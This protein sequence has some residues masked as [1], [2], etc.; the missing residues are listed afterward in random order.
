MPLEPRLDA[1]LS[2]VARRL[3]VAAMLRAAAWSLV[4]AGVVAAVLA[5]QPLGVRVAVA[6]AA[7]VIVCVA[8]AVRARQLA[9]R[10]HAATVAEQHHPAFQNLLVTAEE[11][12]AHPERAAAWVRERVTADATARSAGF[13]AAAAVPL[14][15]AALTAIGAAV[16]A[17]LG[18]G[19]RPQHAAEIAATLAPSLTQGRGAGA[20]TVTVEIEPAAYTGLPRRVEQDPE[21]IEIVGGTRLRVRLAGG[22]GTHRM[23]LGTRA[24]DVRT[25]DGE[26]VA[27]AI[28]EE[29][30]YLAVESDRLDAARLIPLRV[31]PDRAPVV[32]IDAPARDL[33]LPP[34]AA[35]IPVSA[36]AQDDFGLEQLEIRYTKVSGSGEQFEFED[37]T[38]PVQLERN[39]RAWTAAGTLPLDRL[40]L[41]PGD[42][43]VYRAV[44]R[45]ARPGAAGV[46]ESDTFF[47]EIQG[48]SQVLL[49]GLEMPPERERYALSQQMVVMKIERLRAREKE[50]APADVR[51]EAAL[52][53][54]EQ[55]MVRANFIFL[56]GGHVEDEVVE[57]EQ[58]HEIQEGRLEN[59][60]RQEISRAVNLMTAAEMGLTAVNTGE[61][62]PPARAAVQ[63]LQV[64]FGRNRYLLRS[65]AVQSRIDPSRRLTGGLDEAGDWRRARAEPDPA[66]AAAAVRELLSGIVSVISAVAAGDDNQGVRLAQLA[67]HALAMDPEEGTWQEVASSLLA[68][69]DALGA[70]G[71]RDAALE[72]LRAAAVPVASEVQRLARPAT[73]PGTAAPG[74]VERAWAGEGRR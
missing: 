39:D 73:A 41:E 3:G 48:R 46:A 8:T 23:R 4:A 12:E 38:V 11:L 5:W 36:S 42:A 1:I 19:F 65:L 72:R 58:S 53:A 45:D 27:E 35:P 30:T 47:V 68:A 25:V 60:A 15:S 57:A 54:A 14:R 17:A 63:A 56:L 24:L 16:I 74:A 49:E 34:G 6:V 28:P 67:E 70:T 61:A 10:P 44:A 51:E 40:K 2:P 26:D 55:R 69:R 71:D 22:A 62:L 20:L 7:G 18:F 64:A 9:S 59:T 37:G 21:R 32:R 52:I 29:S 50:M 13:D 33:L 31:V 43:L 66:L